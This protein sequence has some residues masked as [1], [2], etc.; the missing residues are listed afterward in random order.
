MQEVDLGGDLTVSRLRAGLS[1]KDIAHLLDIDPGRVSRLEQG[2]SAIRTSELCALAMIYGR[3]MHDL[4]PGLTGQ[5]V[6]EL[7][8]RLTEMPPEPSSWAKFHDLRLDTLNSLF[9]RLQELN[10]EEYGF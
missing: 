10:N 8:E 4:V 5:V 7:R 6:E 2:H 1:N 3:P 9:E